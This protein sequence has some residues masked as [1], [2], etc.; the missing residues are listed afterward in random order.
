[1]RPHTDEARQQILILRQLDLQSALLCLGALGKNIEDQPAAVKHLHAQFLRQ[2]AHLRGREVIVENCHRCLGRADQFLDLRHLALA[3]EAARVRRR[4]VLQH[5]GDAHAA[6]C[7]HKGGKLV[8]ALLVRAVLLQYRRGQTDKDRAV[9]RRF[10]GL[11]F[12]FFH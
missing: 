12:V 11:C 5:R 1:M 9:A 7:L 8:H 3:D 6:R 10:D 4:Q 2:H